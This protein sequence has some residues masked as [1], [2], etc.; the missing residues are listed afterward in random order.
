MNASSFRRRDCLTSHVIGCVDLT[1]CSDLIIVNVVLI[2]CEYAE[3]QVFQ[4]SPRILKTCACDYSSSLLLLD[5]LTYYP[6][7]NPIL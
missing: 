4:Q 6:N 2:S 7:P 1:H 5:V 3:D